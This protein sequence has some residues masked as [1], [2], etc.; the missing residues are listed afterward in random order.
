MPVRRSLLWLALGAGLVAVATFRFWLTTGTVSPWIMV[1]ELIFSE[2][3]RSIA[4]H[5]NL[6]VRGQGFGVFSLLYP[7]LI[8]PAWLIS[9]GKDA[10]EIAKA[11]NSVL[12]T[13]AVVPLYLWSRRLLPVPE[14]VLVCALALLIPP[15]FLAGNLM[16]DN[17]FLPAFLFAAFAIALALERPTYG[18]QALALGAV[19]LACTVRLQG[20]V[21]LLVLPSAV[22]LHALLEPVSAGS[23]GVPAAL[24]RAGRSFLP[25]LLVFVALGLAYA[26]VVLGVGAG[27]SSALGGYQVTTEV[28]YSAAA[29]ARWVAYQFGELDLASGI[30]AIPALSALLAWA[31]RRR[32]ETSPAERAFLAV[33]VSAFFW[34]AIQTGVFASRFSDRVEERLMFYVVPLLL[35]ALVLWLWRLPPQPWAVKAVAFVVPAALLLWLPLGRLLTPVIFS[36]TF[37][38]IPLAALHGMLSLSVVRGILV[39][40]V[41]VS[42]ALF[43]FGPRAVVQLVVPVALAGFLA[44]SSVSTA[45]DMARASRAEQAT[46]E[47]GNHAAWIDDA[48]GGG[49]N[50][51]FLLTPEVDPRALWQLEFWNRALGPVYVLGKSEPGGLPHTSV[52]IDSV[53]GDAHGSGSRP[54][55]AYVVAPRTYAPAGDVVARQGFWVLYR[56]RAPLRLTSRIQGVASDGWIGHRASD[57]VYRASR[58]SS[59]AMTVRIS[60]ASWGGADLPSPVL[61][62]ARSL[63]TGRL[64]AKRTWV[65]HSLGT[66][67][68]PLGTLPEPYRVNVSVPRTFSPADFGLA[69]QRQLGAQVAFDLSRP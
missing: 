11:I 68:F 5:G 8:A 51:G 55:P 37:G 28:G 19:A 18:R 3:A 16:S 26:A 42:G 41:V 31:L 63:P 7:V 15:L 14:S 22:L 58:T 45:R 34:L 35:L 65:V 69:D 33:T 6:D 23:R 44:V 4:R 17:A 2:Q 43:I 30:L 52:M 64:L 12:V 20:L 27:W 1:D 36:D 39:A 62:E 50:V 46:S 60:R 24:K 10:Y 57:I 32:S 66:K 9:S 61:I 49:A 29:A 21:L 54:L 48:V 59:S 13:L 38:L 56:V 25:T 67:T 47:A 40:A 53:D